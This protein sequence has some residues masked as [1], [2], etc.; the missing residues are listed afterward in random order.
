VVLLVPE[1]R[2]ITERKHLEE[3]L[4]TQFVQISTIFDSLNAVVY[5][6]DLESN[7]LLYLNRY[8]AGVFREDWQGSSCCDILHNG[9]AGSCDLCPSSQL[10]RNGVPQPPCLWESHNRATGR[11]YQCIDKGVRWTDG[12]WVRMEIAVDITELKLLEQMKADMVSVLTHEIRTPLTAMLGYIELLLGHGVEPARQQSYLTTIKN[13]TNRLN[14]L[15]DDF[16][17]LQRLE[18]TLLTHDHTPLS[19]Q[20]LLQETV[21][22]FAAASNKHRIEYACAAD[23]P[24]ISGDEGQL[25]RALKNLLSNAVKYSPAGGTVTLGARRE[26]DDV[27]LWVKD[28]GVGIPEDELERIFE[29]F[30]RLKSPAHPTI[31]GTGLGLALVRETV[32]A[33]GGRVWAESQPGT[34]STFYVRLPAMAA[35]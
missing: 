33:H 25:Q 21:D 28:E 32:E 10:V 4:R 31:R 14:D 3:T 20:Q 26:G 27:L 6:A 11:W 15:I 22:L 29:K 5:V 23:L 35:G 30:Y 1:G 7:E 9:S 18:E 19:I 34:G 17:D 13:E 2:D 12:R 24:L 8:G 16:F